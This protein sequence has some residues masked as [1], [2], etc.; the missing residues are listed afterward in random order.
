M[1]NNPKHGTKLEYSEMFVQYAKVEKLRRFFQFKRQRI[2]KHFTRMEYNT[3]FIRK[4]VEDY[5][6]EL[7]EELDMK[8]KLESNFKA[9][10]HFGNLKPSDMVG[11]DN[12][13]D[14][15]A[16]WGVEQTTLAYEDFA[17]D[18]LPALKK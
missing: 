1:R 18:E 17:S 2:F 10:H 12:F 4:F 11:F 14:T 8:G 9:Q 15:L 16:K 3:N 13:Y 6:H 7:D 5:I